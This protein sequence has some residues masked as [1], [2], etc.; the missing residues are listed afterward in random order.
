MVERLL[1]TVLG[2]ARTLLEANGKRRG[3]YI[4]LPR[5][6][7]RPTISKV[8]SPINMSLCAGLVEQGGAD[9]ADKGVELFEV[10]GQVAVDGGD[11]G[12]QVA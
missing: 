5:Q 3:D 7:T 11:L 12:G 2:Y 6:M 10:V 9:C 8:S 1:D 4:R